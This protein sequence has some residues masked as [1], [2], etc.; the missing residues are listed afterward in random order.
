M[1]LPKAHRE[2][3]AT[4]FADHPREVIEVLLETCLDLKKE[5]ESEAWATIHDYLDLAR[6]E[7]TP[8]YT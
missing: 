8:L 6:Q 5:Y 4:L 7:A 1:P 3:I 2:M